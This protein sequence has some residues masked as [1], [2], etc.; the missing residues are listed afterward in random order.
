L[1]ELTIIGFGIELTIPWT[2][3]GVQANLSDPF[4]NFDNLVHYVLQTMISNTST[5][6]A[7][8]STEVNTKVSKREYVIGYPFT[9]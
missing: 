7:I 8:V 4:Y 5:T 1:V 2:G 3:L 9:A 6:S